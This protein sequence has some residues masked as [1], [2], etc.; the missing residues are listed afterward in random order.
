[1]ATRA[2]Q[3]N[4]NNFLGQI[5]TSQAK[6]GSSS[7]TLVSGVLN[8]SGHTAIGAGG[9]TIEGW[10]YITA[11]GSG[12]I[13]SPTGVS[14]GFNTQFTF[15]A[16]QQISTIT[17][18]NNTTT[19]ATLNLSTPLSVLNRWVHYA[20]QRSGSTVSVYLDGSYRIGAISSTSDT[21]TTFTLGIISSGT[22]SGYF[23]EQRISSV[24]RY[25]GTT[26]TIPSA[27]F[28]DDASTKML[29]HFE[30][31]DGTVLVNDD[32]GTGILKDP[33]T[34]TK[35]GTIALNTTEKMYGTGSLKFNTPA[36]TNRMVM[37]GT[38]GTLNY[39]A[40]SV[41][42]S[43]SPILTQ[44]LTYEFFIYF[45]ESPV[46][47][48]E[49]C[50]FANST[51]TTSTSTPRMYVVP[52]QWKFYTSASAQITLST[53]GANAPAAGQ[54][55]HIAIQYVAQ[56]NGVG[57]WSF[58]VNGQW[59][60]T[61]TT[62]TNPNW[63]GWYWGAHGRT[64]HVWTTGFSI[65]DLRITKGSYV[66]YPPGV[67]FQP[68]LSQLTADKWTTYL[69]NAN[70]A[71]PTEVIY[72]GSV[73][74][75]GAAAL[76]SAFTFDS[77][78]TIITNP[79]KEASA[80]LNSNF[81]IDSIGNRNIDATSSINLIASFTG[82]ISHIEGAD[83]IINGFASVDASA[84][85]F[86]LADT[87]IASESTF[88]ADAERIPA[89]MG[90]TKE[91]NAAL[92][93]VSTVSMTSGY[94]LDYLSDLTAVASIDA[95]ISHIEGADL[96]INGF[97]SFEATGVL[98]RDTDSLFV[99]E[100]S[101]SIDAALIKDVAIE[102]NTQVSI[103]MIADKYAAFDSSMSSEFI[104]NSTAGKI[105]SAQGDFVAE[106]TQTSTI[107]HLEGADLFAMSEAALEGV[108]SRL[109][110]NNIAADV[111]FDVATD[112]VRYRSANVDEA[113]EFTV[114]AVPQRSCDFASNVQVA[115]SFA[116]NADNVEFVD[117]SLDASFS[118]TATGK[119]TRKL[120]SAQS[121]VAT[122][123]TTATRI[124]NF[125][126]LGFTPRTT[127][128][129]TLNGNTAVS[130]AQKK[131]GAGS[132]A[133]DGT[134]DNLVTGNNSVF[135]WGTT[136]SWTVEMNFFRN[137]NSAQHTLFD[138]RDASGTN[139]LRV[140]VATNGYIY[141]FYSNGI[142]GAPTL[143][144][145]PNNTWTHIA[146]TFDKA[147]ET[148]R[149]FV[150]GV[151]KVTR[152][153][154]VVNFTA[155]P[156]T[157][158][159]TYLGT[160]YL[161][162][163][164]DEVRIS[165]V[166]RYTAG[167]TAPTTAFT[168]DANTLLLLH[169]DTTIADDYG[170]LDYIAP[171]FVSTFTEVVE[172]KLQVTVQLNGALFAEA[173]LA[174][175]IN[176]VRGGAS[177]AT[178]DTNLT[179][180]ISHI[181]GADLIIDGFATLEAFAGTIHN[182][183]VGLVSNFFTNIVNPQWYRG[184]EV[185]AVAE[186]NF[187]TYAV[188][189][190]VFDTST[191]SAFDIS[192]DSVRLK[193]ADS[194]QDTTTDITVSGD[195]YRLGV[196][197]ETITVDFTADAIIPVEVQGD[198]AVASTL[199]VETGFLQGQLVTTSAEFTQ[200]ATALGIRVFDS[201]LSADTNLAAV[202]SNI[203]GVDIVAF[204]YASLAASFDRT[205]G[206]VA[207][208]QAD[209]AVNISA[210]VV[211]PGSADIASEFTQ[212]ATGIRY[213]PSQASIASD[214]AVNVSADIKKVY[215]AHV[216]LD[217]SLT[218][219]GTADRTVNLAI[220]SDSSL[221]VNYT[222]F[223]DSDTALD[224]TTVINVDGNTFRGMTVA[225]DS[226]FEHAVEYTR[227]RDTS[228]NTA[229]ETTQVTDAVKHVEAIV[230]PMTMFNTGVIAVA[231][232]NQVAILVTNTSMATTASTTKVSAMT[233]ASDTT[234]TT[235]A[236]GYRAFD[237]Q[238]YM[239]FTAVATAQKKVTIGGIG[240]N[241]VPDPE[242]PLDLPSAFS[243]NIVAN[244][245]TYKQFDSALT[246]NASIT[247]A[248]DRTRATASS[249]SIQFATTSTATRIKQGALAITSAFSPTLNVGAVRNDAVNVHVTTTMSVT[250]TKKVYIGGPGIG[251]NSQS[252]NAVI[253]SDLLNFNS[254]TYQTVSNLAK[255]LR[256]SGDFTAFYTNLTVIS[257][258]TGFGAEI[259]SSS[260]LV[261]GA[262]IIR[263]FASHL[264]STAE[265]TAVATKIEPVYVNMA[266]SF[267]LVANNRE[268]H[269]LEQVYVIPAEGR[270]FSIASETRNKV[271]SSE[272]RIANIRR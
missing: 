172:A 61:S 111:A 153:F 45:H 187:Y 261:A 208:A 268:I 34:I 149:F 248:F 116:C 80:D 234:M 269:I 119:V 15:N 18:Q 145:P 272:T 5:T 95:T 204:D 133:F 180:T 37:G 8:T 219:T 42:A 105:A 256:T 75:L 110:D 142:K 238:T 46:T 79:V 178:A 108:V 162:G 89:A 134:G 223:R 47:A 51:G 237:V 21:R 171:G 251:G 263:G 179:A 241:N 192:L 31:A 76:N 126:T 163:Y 112:Y 113:A 67:V 253:E 215:D 160:E 41:P 93:I 158:G 73:T 10:M 213:T 252:G 118:T 190:R 66:R 48:S 22:I 249:A 72:A 165:K 70:N 247:A 185:Q 121:A 87:S 197:N 84:D 27:A 169:G 63:N 189:Y 211:Q 2:I 209:L 259:T 58:A 4:L 216:S 30:G 115:F 130:T 91:F 98:V 36:T 155:A 214:F 186:S 132:I 199:A 260:T 203:K 6:F 156:L 32:D 151:L 254:V 81:T 3:V 107:S 109:R 228:S 26:Y 7:A 9:F 265:F 201:A 11:A 104:Q 38:G 264:D 196:V 28:V 225:F 161:N 206:F 77:T 188:G 62:I 13:F 224:A 183:Q 243:I 125:N 174:A 40:A 218:A 177:S 195:R 257:K 52:G 258:E 181:E 82:T 152:G 59:S 271:I 267:G 235:V 83:L 39:L 143:L 182:K 245:I 222:R 175:D 154:D 53:S 221:A 176:V 20:I 101:Q 140:Y 244:K 262:E 246:T 49:R 146:V 55:F 233:V 17:I 150:D 99:V 129:I 240:S 117:A 97:A 167:F 159:S 139:N 184:H 148:T 24:A 12:A 68:P 106:F 266:A 173:I 74:H 144:S 194:T 147:T 212:T 122:V 90:E 19:I 94:I 127:R 86:R 250:A 78:T 35:T 205:R 44:N 198:F 102:L 230:N 207:N 92:D 43:G 226:N 242:V 141:M 71:T 65:D 210:G 200:T 14:T 1:M 164:I 220:Q 96:I 16:S 124:K 54:W 100:A 114:N 157:L 231:T 60:D 85:R 138:M 69:T 131:I 56:S 128:T 168:N 123:S 270:A 191:S 239:E 193:L 232:M 202:I 229:I 23:D 50:F 33:V 170:P 88:T 236:R 103:S 57:L 136:S 255:V 64:G 135:G 137:N 25:S 217:T 227:Y 166:A 29:V 120:A